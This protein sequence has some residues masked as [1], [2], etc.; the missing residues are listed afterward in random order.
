MTKYL[1]D[2]LYVA[3]IVLSGFSSYLIDKNTVG[4]EPEHGLNA[5]LKHTVENINIV[6]SNNNKTKSI[7]KLPVNSEIPVILQNKTPYNHDEIS[8]ELSKPEWV[9]KDIV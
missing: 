7:V 6:R 1:K 5:I 2:I 9:S 4:N 3:G 8:I